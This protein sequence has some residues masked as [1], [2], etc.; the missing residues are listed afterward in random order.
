MNL[1]EVPPASLVGWRVIPS[2]TVLRA[3][4]HKDLGIAAG[5]RSADAIPAAGWTV[6]FDM[7]DDG[8]TDGFVCQRTDPD[9]KVHSVLWNADDVW[10]FFQ[11]ASQVIRAVSDQ[12]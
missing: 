11:P 3:K 8:C 9:G 6:A 7:R 4:L 12:E 5:N 10:M 2:L 1:A